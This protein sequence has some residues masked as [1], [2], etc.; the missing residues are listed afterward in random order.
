M[1]SVARGGRPRR[2][3]DAAVFASTLVS[4][5]SEG[6][7]ATTMDRIAATAGAAKTTL[8][9]RWPSKTALV[10]DCLVDAF[11]DVPHLSG[12]RSEKAAAVV[13]WIAGHIARPGVG[14][15]FAGVFSEAITNPAAREPLLRVLQE[16]YARTLSQDLGLTTNRVLLYV[17]LVVGTLLHRLGISGAPMTDAD[18]EALIGIVSA[19]LAAEH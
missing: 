6:Y 14:A 15:A 4:V 8:Y 10:V 19:G 9:R 11:G 3:L 13:R 2:D 16:P 5:A 17:D 1:D 18:V 7:A 12:D